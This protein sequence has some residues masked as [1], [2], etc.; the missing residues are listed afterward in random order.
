MF[1]SH[2]SYGMS[3]EIVRAHDLGLTVRFFD[4]DCVEKDSHCVSSSHDVANILKHSKV[5]DYLEDA[6][7]DIVDEFATAL[8]VAIG[9]LKF[10]GEDDN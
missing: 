3:V 5:W 4:E 9:Y 10:Y 8:G 1:G 6:P 2:T 7:E